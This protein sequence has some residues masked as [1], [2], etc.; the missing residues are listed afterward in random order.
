[1]AL[2]A[3][4]AIRNLGLRIPEDIAIIG[5]DNR[6]IIAAHMH[7]ALTTVALPYYEMGKKAFEILQSDEPI[8][9]NTIYI[10]CPL[11]VRNSV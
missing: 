9:N 6:E 8:Q 2:G 7:P 10:D 3:Y 4:D 5:F 1:M 11:V